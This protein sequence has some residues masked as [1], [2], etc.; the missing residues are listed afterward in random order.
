MRRNRCSGGR[1]AYRWGGPTALALGVLTAGATAPG[2]AQGGP[3]NSGALFL[4]FPVGARAVGMGGAAFADGG[5][6]EAAFWNP[7]GLAT[8]PAASFELHTVSL[9]AGRTSAVSAHFPSSRIGVFGGAIYLVDYGDLD[10]TDSSSTTIA[11]ISPRNMEFLASFAT[12]LPG[13]LS[14]GVSYKL[15]TFQ[16]D[17]SGDCSGLPNG[18]GVTH[19]VDAGVQFAVGSHDALTVGVALRNLGFALQ[20]E[21]RDQADPLPTTLGV[22]ALWQTA[23]GGADREH[24]FDLRVAADVDRPWTGEAPPGIRFGLDVG[25]R[26]VARARAGYGV[27]SGGTAS[28]SVGLGVASGAIG[29][30]LAQTFLSDSD[31]E[32]A[33]PTFFSFRVSF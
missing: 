27:S 24:H 25:Y 33:S 30:D 11:R 2:A 20:I 12:A 8:V 26:R 6:G 3:S 13:L 23:L 5:T 14:L 29:V 28:A 21:N 32:S 10:R 1:P 22:G 4:E 31:L 15:V 18:N 7:A 16:V 9:A 19:A 17:C